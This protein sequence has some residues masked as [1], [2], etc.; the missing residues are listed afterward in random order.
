MDIDKYLLSYLFT[1]EKFFKEKKLSYFKTW[2]DM[3]LIFTKSHI[4]NLYQMD[5]LPIF[6][7]R[8]DSKLHSLESPA[9][10]PQL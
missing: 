10:E 3:N 1:R 2:K 5:V 8:V 4:S 6:M 7:V 9:E